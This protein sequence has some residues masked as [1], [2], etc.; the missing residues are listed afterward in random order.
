M[1]GALP[2]NVSACCKRGLLEL[3]KPPLAVNESLEGLVGI[4]I[5]SSVLE[6]LVGSSYEVRSRFRGV[7][8]V[9]IYV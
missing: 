9:A 8:M 3:I 2:E 4:W 6:G 5:S 7:S 1:I